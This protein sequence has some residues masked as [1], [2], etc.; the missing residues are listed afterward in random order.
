MHLLQKIQQ[1]E[2]EIISF[3][4]FSLPH[5]FQNQVF[6]ISDFMKLGPEI[7]NNMC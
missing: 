7:P 4:M 1:N 2:R 3:D 5:S 6:E